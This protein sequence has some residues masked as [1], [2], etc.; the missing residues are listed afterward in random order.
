[1]KKYIKNYYKILKVD[2][3]A[4]QKTI[5]KA[6]K[7]LTLNYHPDVNNNEEDEKKFLSIKEAYSVLSDPDKRIKYDKIYDKIQENKLKQKKEKKNHKN[8]TLNLFKDI[9]DNFGIASKGGK[10]LSGS[11]KS[12]TLSMGTKLLLGGAAA[13]IGVNRGRKYLKKSGKR[14]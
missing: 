4:N 8:D 11:L 7:K 5:K 14:F 3:Y 2:R 10:I 12:Q 13:G 6:Y 9:E 1:M